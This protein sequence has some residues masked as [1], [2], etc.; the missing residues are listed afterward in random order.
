[1]LKNGQLTLRW[2]CAGHAGIPIANGYSAALH[3]FGEVGKSPQLPAPLIRVPQGTEILATVQNLL[4][5]AVTVHGLH[6]HVGDANDTLEVAAG[7]TRE[8]RFKVGRLL[9]PTR[10]GR[11]PRTQN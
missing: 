11:P 1:M 2:N 4:P 6:N 8:V 9:G 5:A 7:A 3:A 10:I